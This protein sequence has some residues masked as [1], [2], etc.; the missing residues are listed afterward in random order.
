MCAASFH[1]SVH[2][3]HIKHMHS[4][5]KDLHFILWPPLYEVKIL[6]G[7][8]QIKYFSYKTPNNL[9]IILTRIIS[10]G[11]Y[12][13]SSLLETIYTQ[14]CT[15]ILN[16]FLGNNGPTIYPQWMY[17]LSS[18]SHRTWIVIFTR[19]LFYWLYPTGVFFCFCFFN[20]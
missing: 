3:A 13:F 17:H 18:I 16:G 5:K 7:G 8:C 19:M 11:L 4:N 10:P 15:L 20:R 14:T 1:V 6:I 12:Y 2:F 9:H